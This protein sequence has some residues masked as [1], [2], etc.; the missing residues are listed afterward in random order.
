MSGALR[1]VADAVGAAPSSGAVSAGRLA[2]LVAETRARR[3]AA[4]PAQTAAV[5][6]QAMTPLSPEEFAD[7]QRRIMR[8]EVPDP[9][10][11]A[12]RVLM[13]RLQ[14]TPDYT[15]V[16]VTK[17]QKAAAAESAA[18]QAV[19]EIAPVDGEAAARPF[20]DAGK[21]RLV[22]EAD[23]NVTLRPLGDGEHFVY[24]DGTVVDVA[25][26]VKGRTNPDTLTDASA[27]PV[28]DPK[29]EAS[30][31][32]IGEESPV[33]A[34][35]KPKRGGKDNLTPKQAKPDDA[36]D[37]LAQSIFAEG[38]PSSTE[39]RNRT[40]LRRLVKELQ[41]RRGP[42][43]QY[44]PD[45]LAKIS[46][47]PETAAARIAAVEEMAGVSN[48]DRAAEQIDKAAQARDAANTVRS[49]VASPAAAAGDFGAARELVSETLPQKGDWSG[50]ADA[51]NRLDGIQRQRIM[52]QLPESIRDTLLGM[53]D[54]ND[55]T[56]SL[57]PNLVAIRTR[58]D[59]IPA[60]LQPGSDEAIELA[61]A[62]NERGQAEDALRKALIDSH[63]MVSEE[64]AAM[65][66][67]AVPPP[68]PAVRSRDAETPIT[69]IDELHSNEL[70][71]G[72]ENATAARRESQD[73]LDQRAVGGGLTESRRKQAFGLSDDDEM[74]GM[75]LY[76]RNR[77][78]NPTFEESTVAGRLTDTN[79]AKAIAGGRA[80]ED[81]I[82]AAHA[83]Y[84]AAVAE[85]RG[86]KD[87]GVMAPAAQKVAMAR[88]RLDDAYAA[89]DDKWPARI[90][91]E[92]TGQVEPASDM[93]ASGEM[94]VPKGWVLERGRKAWSDRAIN[95]PSVMQTYND[96][97]VSMLGW[98]PTPKRAL[99]RSTPDIHSSDAAAM[100]DE[101]IRHFG[102]DAEDLME[103]DFD[104]DWSVEGT[105]DLAS[106]GSQKQSR[107]GGTHQ[108]SREQGGTDLIFGGVNPF[109]LLDAEGVPLFTNADEVAE[110]VLSGNSLFR[111]GT[112][113]YAMA[114][115]RLARIVNHR[116]GDAPKVDMRPKKVDP[117]TPSGDLVEP[118]T[119]DTAVSGDAI[120][121]LEG[122]AVDLDT[123]STPEKGKGGRRGKKATA[124]PAVSGDA[125]TPTVAGGDVKIKTVEEIQKEANAVEKQV[126][127]EAIQNGASKSAADAEARAARKKHVDAE[128]AAR[129]QAIDGGAVTP[130]TGDGA[131]AT[132]APSAGGAGKGPPDDPKTPKSDVD[133][134]AVT[135][136]EG[137]GGPV[138]VDG[139]DGFDS[140]LGPDDPPGTKP[141]DV[142]E[143][144]GGEKTGETAPKPTEKAPGKT[145]LGRAKSPFVWGPL[146]IG[147]G[148]TAVSNLLRRPNDGGV[149]PEGM[150]TGGGG[151]GG[152][153]PSGGPPPIPVNAGNV[154]DVP[155]DAEQAEIDR[156]NR[157]L[158]RIRGRAAMNKV[159]TFQTV[160]NYN[161]WR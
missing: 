59:D 10:N 26:N 12:D 98:R 114:K 72:F 66:R 160:Q 6:A 151:G 23:P 29:L 124:K 36:D 32:E 37:L 13:L 74:R 44:S 118:V 46:P 94:P 139:R 45:F 107:L 51:F 116:F 136:V 11:P 141:K 99:G 130:V 111:P 15:G 103:G 159:P 146:A 127:K 100:R 73:A 4:T 104:P 91:N 150:E 18:K 80:M 1:T 65:R 95:R 88:K 52:A 17:A 47:D 54:P 108:M 96:A 56:H 142:A 152:T 138:G 125:V 154:L 149:P 93:I 134:D 113:N 137:D 64:K 35:P 50:L 147:A 121:P 60:G 48:V 78:R 89:M 76:L 97:L 101:A 49:P 132:P 126:R 105:S 41:L 115:D 34:A 135:D 84:D 8:G 86:A 77:D 117:A 57:L 128:M 68:Q 25:G 75:P 81:E 157:A 156:I 102:S 122:S 43:G 61:R 38:N 71:G 7:Y 83:E 82:N 133:G 16:P 22:S 79:D 145:W 5:N 90:V 67:A 110:Q 19:A 21:G 119:G 27:T 24:E 123:G 120:D 14:I 39:V 155:E 131:A 144:T 112:A 31:V 143:G 40:T 140:P 148:I 3:A 158:D 53:A 33:P 106:N 87:I 85:L 28:S 30:A 20:Y 55:P 161:G 92:S 69:A 109:G 9:E 63:E 58:P 42:D 2:Q 62:A 129:K 70:P 153:G